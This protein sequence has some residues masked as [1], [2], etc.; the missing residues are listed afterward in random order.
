MSLTAQP[1][2]LILLTDVGSTTTKAVLLAPVGPG[3]AYR[4]AGR[5]DAATTVEAPDENVI[6]G[7]RRAVAEL[8][9]RAGTD[10]LGRPGSGQRLARQRVRTYL[11]TSS[12]GGGLQ[13][14]VC[15]VMR[16]LTAKSAEQAALGAG[17]IVLDVLAVDDDRTPLQRFRAISAARPDMVLVAGGMDGGTPRFVLETCDFLNLSEMRPRFG[18][19][20]RLPVVFAGAESVRELVAEM[21]SRRYDVL[22]APNLRPDVSK[23]NLE[24]V[25]RAIVEIFESHVMKQ[26]PGYEE[27]LT[28]VD[29]PVLP[30]PVAVGLILKLLSERE[31]R[32]VLCM[33]LGGATTDVF[34][35]VDGRFTR[36]VS[37]NLGVSYSSSN[38]MAQAGPARIASWL[39]FAVTEDDLR[40]E[41]GSKT[42]HPTTIPET[43]RELFVEQAL[44]TEAIRLATEQHLTVLQPARGP[45][46]VAFGRRDTELI[47]AREAPQASMA[48]LRPGLV[49]G[50][51][52]LLASAPLRAQAA[53]ILL[54]SVRPGGVMRLFVDSVFMLPH[55]GVLSQTEPAIATE[56]LYADC[57]VDLGTAVQARPVDV[58]GRRGLGGVAGRRARGPSEGG[59]V[60]ATLTA[61]GGRKA[62]LR[63]SRDSIG[64]LPL[65][66]G[67]AGEALLQPHGNQDFGGGPGNTVSISVTGGA[68]GLMIDNRLDAGGD[69]A[70]WP[71]PERAA[72]VRRWL[73]AIGAWPEGWAPADGGDREV[74]PK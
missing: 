10:L 39:P 4:L 1:P 52:G 34:S 66:P 53:M 70:A 21:L 33:D 60:T 24:P 55:L 45:R 71:G 58:A 31:R 18:E 54:N 25:R 35:F 69:A 65:A 9:R 48:D 72:Q 59:D 67:L 47:K 40:D 56:V 11:S 12:A 22:L 15:G 16:R 41:I 23:E 46:E 32:N 50:S 5:A 17:A 3:G 44:A 7:V 42:L 28:W 13:V 27:M 74:P 63:V 8:G 36:S 68:I 64:V 73:A 29:G 14:M 37:A 19:G 6:V 61:A 30:T 38:V 49:I 51:G 26:A 43:L 62:E 57:L 2:D 20:Y